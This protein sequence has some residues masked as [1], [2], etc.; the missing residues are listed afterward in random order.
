MNL[1]PQGTI[2]DFKPDKFH[3][4]LDPE[5]F[6]FYLRGNSCEL[7]RVADEIGKLESVIQAWFK[8]HHPW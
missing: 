8:T 1:M 4:S 6:Q 3:R 5:T 2:S 7:R